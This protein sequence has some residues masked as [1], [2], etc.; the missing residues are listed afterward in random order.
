MTLS[1]PVEAAYGRVGQAGVTGA[2]DP[3]GVGTELGG[4]ATTASVGD[5]PTQ[6]L[7]DNVP[8]RGAVQDRLMCI[9]GG[10]SI[11]EVEGGD[12]DSELHVTWW[13][14]KMKPEF[15]EM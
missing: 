14:E 11:L 13:R 12:V 7:Q 2:V 3:V 1:V 8:R 4:A 9:L 15:D 6:D 10:W 5:V